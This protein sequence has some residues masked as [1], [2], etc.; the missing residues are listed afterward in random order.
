MPKGSMVTDEPPPSSPP[1]DVHAFTSASPSAAGSPP[2]PGVVIEIDMSPSVSKDKAALME[3]K[4]EAM[5]LRQ[6]KKVEERRKEREERTKKERE[7]REELVAKMKEGPG[8]GAGT[9]R[10]KK[11]W[12]VGASDKAVVLQ[13]LR[14]RGEKGVSGASPPFPAP[15][16]AS[17]PPVAKVVRRRQSKNSAG[18]DEG[19]NTL[20]GR[21]ERMKEDF[22]RQGP[23]DSPK[24][25]RGKAAS[26]A[27]NG[28]FDGGRDDGDRFSDR[29]KDGSNN[30]F[31][32]LL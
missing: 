27:K 6:E 22:G 23:I 13:T 29:S 2:P 25:R 3:K 28:N 18:E 14:S 5:R 9:S 7:E 32:A 17:P 24:I 8:M 16:P 1:R 30:P 10:K 26:R 15:T 11:G 21:L 4:R 12:G 31:A 19:I 20:V